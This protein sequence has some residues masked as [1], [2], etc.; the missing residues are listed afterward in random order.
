MWRKAAPATDC[1]RSDPAVAKYAELKYRPAE[2]HRLD[3]E[4]YTEA[5]SPFIA[6]ILLKLA[7]DSRLN[8]ANLR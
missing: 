2:A 5:K 7:G 6:R 8:G 1:L 4:A 3:Q